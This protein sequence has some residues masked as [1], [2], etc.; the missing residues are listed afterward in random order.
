MKLKLS[1]I[2]TNVLGVLVLLSLAGGATLFAM[3]KPSFHWQKPA[4]A[5][6]VTVDTTPVAPVVTPAPVVATPEPTPAP[7]APV[8]KTA[9]TNSFVHLRKGPSTSTDILADLQ[10]GRDVAGP[11]LAVAH[12]DHHGVEGRGG[13]HRAGAGGAQQGI[14]TGPSRPLPRPRYSAGMPAAM[15]AWRAGFWPAPAA[16]IWPRMISVTS[17]GATFARLS[18]SAMAMFPN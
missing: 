12:R 9:T 8:V 15:A 5:A 17:P 10:G 16:R 6:P 3:S 2:I 4:P 1:T 18:A 13:V 14:G 7:A 11:G